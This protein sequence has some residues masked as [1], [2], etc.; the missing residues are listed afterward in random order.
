MRINDVKYGLYTY[1]NQINR[2]KEKTNLNKS[3]GGDVVSISSKGQEISQA[4][5]SDQLGSQN[6]IEQL[7]QQIANGTYHVDSQKIAGK[8]IDF[9]K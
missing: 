6:K 2:N 5:K 9:W 8:M 3:T 7:K 1:Q 4:M